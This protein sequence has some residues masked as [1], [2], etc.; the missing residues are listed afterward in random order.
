VGSAG[1]RG[2]EGEVRGIPGIV[3]SAEGARELILFLLRG[4]VAAKWIWDMSS[5]ESFI[6]L[7]IK[8]IFKI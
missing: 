2:S 3:A 4:A 5:L 6:F 1:E 7:K 8:L